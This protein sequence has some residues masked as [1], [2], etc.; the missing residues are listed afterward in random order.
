MES[1]SCGILKELKRLAPEAREQGI[2]LGR[3]GVW[4]SFFYKENLDLKSAW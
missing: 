4:I 2:V 3:R 1:L